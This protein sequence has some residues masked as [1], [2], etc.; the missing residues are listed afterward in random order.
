MYRAGTVPSSARAR[1]FGGI[2]PKS[3]PRVQTSGSQALGAGMNGAAKG[4]RNSFPGREL[5]EFEQDGTPYFRDRCGSSFGAGRATG[6]AGPLAGAVA[7]G[8]GAG[9]LAGVGACVGLEESAALDHVAE[10]QGEVAA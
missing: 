5:V 6:R 8:G 9:G 7:Q 1:K 4:D 2:C 3:I 10:G